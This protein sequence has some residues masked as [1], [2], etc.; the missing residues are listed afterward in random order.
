MLNFMV[1]QRCNK[2]IRI[3]KN[4]INSSHKNLENEDFWAENLIK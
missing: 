2:K 4:L 3:D 1:I